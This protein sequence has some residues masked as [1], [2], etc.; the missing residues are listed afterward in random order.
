MPAIVVFL[1]SSAG[2]ANPNYASVTRA[3]NCVTMFRLCLYEKLLTHFQIYV[4]NAVKHFRKVYI[5]A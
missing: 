4:A 2:Y 5:N 3:V 1:M